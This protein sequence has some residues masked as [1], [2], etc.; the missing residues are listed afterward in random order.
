MK[1]SIKP[2][3]NRIDKLVENKINEYKESL[4]YELGGERV[5]T[6]F[7]AMKILKEMPFTL[8]TQYMKLFDHYRVK[9]SDLLIM[10]NN[11]DKHASLVKA[12]TNSKNVEFSGAVNSETGE[13]AYDEWYKEDYKLSVKNFSKNIDVIKERL[14]ASYEAGEIRTKEFWIPVTI[15]VVS[16]IISMSVGLLSIFID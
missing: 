15:S 6:E 3:I 12:I 1:P 11:I 5:L 7:G 16:L 13:L 14:K 9:K 2:D 10:L 8:L 4:P